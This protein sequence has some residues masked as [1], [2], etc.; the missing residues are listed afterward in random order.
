M[1]SITIVYDAD[2]SVNIRRPKLQ[3]L[4]NAVASTSYQWQGIEMPD[5]A[6]LFSGDHFM[7]SSKIS[8]L[9][10]CLLMI[11]AI[12]I[13]LHV[14][15]VPVLLHA[16]GRD[17]WLAELTALPLVALYWW[18]IVKIARKASATQP[19]LQQIRWVW[20]RLL[21][22]AVLELYVVWSIAKEVREWAQFSVIVTLPGAPV[23]LLIIVILAA[24]A[25]IARK[26]LPVIAITIGFLLPVVF[27][28]GTTNTLSTLSEKDY[29]VLFPVLE[30]GIAPVLQGVEVVLPVVGEFFL[31]LFILHHVNGE[32]ARSFFPWLI[33]LGILFGAIG[34]GLMA[35]LL[36]EY[37]PEEIIHHR[38]PAFEGWRMVTFGTRFERLDF[39]AIYQWIVGLCG[40]VMLLLFIGS[41]VVRNKIASRLILIILTLCSIAFAAWSLPMDMAQFTDQ[42]YAKVAMGIDVFLPVVFAS[43]LFWPRRRPARGVA[44]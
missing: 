25:W 12:A 31:V 19:I 11:A 32:K 41:D 8:L 15:I 20:L 16:S 27:L 43:S 37:G 40:R 44:P 10:A 39:L 14:T 3:L 9:H 24:N 36:A 33:T 30:Q 1:I 13:P 26:G 23:L 2:D 17:A 34:V 35:G 42:L 38:Y 4:V 28:F 6:I 22:I 18:L 7:E 21:V 29:G 5:E